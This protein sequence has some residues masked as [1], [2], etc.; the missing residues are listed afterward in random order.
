MVAPGV[1]ATALAVWDARTGRNIRTIARAPFDIFTLDVSPDGRYVAAATY[2]NYDCPPRESA[3]VWDMATGKHVFIVHSGVEGG[4]VIHCDVLD[5]AFSRDGKYLA[6][7]TV[8]DAKIYTPSGSRLLQ[9]LS[10]SEHG[11]FRARFSS[12]GSLLATADYDDFANARPDRVR[13]WDWREGRVLSV[14]ASRVNNIVFP[15]DF[16]PS[17]S[18]I[19]TIDPQGRAEILDVRSEKLVARLQGEPGAINDF[20][21]SPDGSLV[22]TAGY[23]GAVGLFEADTGARRFVLPGPCPVSHV[24]FSPDGTKL[25]TT[26][27][28]P[29]EHV[30]GCGAVRIWAL[31]ID[32]LLQ[33]AREKVTRPLTAEECRQYLNEDRCP[34]P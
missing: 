26:Q 33:I 27:G 28:W 20:K 22:A 5:L 12:D 23:D 21:F 10:D 4:A 31:D 13:I 17:G 32:D 1:D 2:E 3:G 6:A 19:V 29:E 9:T 30:P 7:A 24:S 34:A 25:A 16:D 11:M 14:I 8:G 18:R 15:L